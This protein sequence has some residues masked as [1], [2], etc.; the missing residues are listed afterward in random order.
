MAFGVKNSSKKVERQ[1]A[2][3]LDDNFCNQIQKD[4]N[5]EFVHKLIAYNGPIFDNNS[6]PVDYVN[7]EDILTDRKIKK[8]YAVKV[9]DED[10]NP[11]IPDR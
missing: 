8:K 3:L 4:L 6:Y 2:Y 1:A 9:F 11:V 7:I 5:I 10:L